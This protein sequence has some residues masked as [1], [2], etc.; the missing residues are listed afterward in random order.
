MCVLL[1]V[2]YVVSLSVC[3]LSY[4]LVC[5]YYLSFF[6][7]CLLLILSVLCYCVV[8]SYGCLDDDVV[9]CGTV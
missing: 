9:S 8:C 7:V 5:S 3:L 6:S 4:C 2:V 1:C